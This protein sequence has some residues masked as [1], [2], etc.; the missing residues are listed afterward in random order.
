[1]TIQN[2]ILSKRRRYCTQDPFLLINNPRENIFRKVFTTWNTTDRKLTWGD[3]WKYEPLRF[4]F[5]LR[6]VYDLLPSP[7][8]LCRW[9]LTT[10][11]KCSLC[12]KP[13]TLDHVLLS[14]STA[15]TQGRYRWRHDSVLREFAGWLEKERKRNM[16]ITFNTGR[17][18]LSSQAIPERHRQHNLHCGIVV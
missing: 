14:C 10:D 12:D 17:L 8:N 4:S 16:V 18:P 2:A 5:L 7:A 1:M 9:G 3:I 6:S 13:G 15:L 11:P